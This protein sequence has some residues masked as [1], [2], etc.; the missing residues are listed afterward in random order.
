MEAFQTATRA[1]YPT[2]LIAWPS[3]DGAQA[4]LLLSGA[5]GWA[6]KPN[7]LKIGVRTALLV[8]DDDWTEAGF[9]KPEL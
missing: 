8:S 7:A 1:F 5:I 3:S 2:G 6:H 4:Y 9:D